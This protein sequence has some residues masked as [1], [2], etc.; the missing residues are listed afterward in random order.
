MLNVHGRPGI[1]QQGSFV[2]N[3]YFYL[4]YDTDRTLL[5]EWLA[6][7]KCIKIQTYHGELAKIMGLVFIDCTNNPSYAV[8]FKLRFL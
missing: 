1:I 3:I 6:D 8:D 5:K 4:L 2:F 7:N